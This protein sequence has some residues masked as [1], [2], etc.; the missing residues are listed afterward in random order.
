MG[1]RDQVLESIQCHK[2]KV[3]NKKL[4]NMNLFVHFYYN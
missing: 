2:H 3:F 1:S 4:N